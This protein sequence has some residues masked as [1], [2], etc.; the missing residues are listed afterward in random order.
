MLVMIAVGP[1]YYN[2]ALSAVS[3]GSPFLCSFSIYIHVHIYADLFC[4]FLPSLLG[5]I[6]KLFNAIFDSVY[7]HAGSCFFYP[8]LRGLFAI[9]SL[10]VEY[11]SVLTSV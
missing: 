5:V 2:F 9:C 4:V 1:V 3:K 6:R 10:R 11:V 8:E 7:A